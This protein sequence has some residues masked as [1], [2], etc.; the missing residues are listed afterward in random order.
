M[1]LNSYHFGC[2]LCSLVGGVWRQAEPCRR[3]KSSPSPFATVL[4][5]PQSS[6]EPAR[7]QV[8]FP[9]G[10]LSALLADMAAPVLRGVQKLLKLVDFTPVPRRHR[11]KK[12]WVR[13]D[14]RGKL[15]QLLRFLTVPFGTSTPGT[16]S[17]LELL[18][19]LCLL[20]TPPLSIKSPPELSFG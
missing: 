2:S 9:V 15:I 3:G 12:K 20:L 8:L 10:V 17:Y 14:T 16:V 7:A 5:R 4:S 13:S 18:S 11:Y 1:L 6:P 19:H